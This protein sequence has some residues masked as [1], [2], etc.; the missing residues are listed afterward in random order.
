MSLDR[1][2]LSTESAIEVRSADDGKPAVLTG[3]AAL[4][5]HDSQLLGPPGRQFIERIAPGAFKRSVDA[6]GDIIATVDHEDRLILGRRSSGTLTLSENEKGLFV[7]VSLPNT[8]Y[9]S[10]LVESVQRGDISGMSFSFKNPQ[11][12]WGKR[13]VEGR[14]VPTRT[15]SDLELVEVAFVI[16]PA[17][18]QTDIA[19]RSLSN[20]EERIASDHKSNERRLVLA[21]AG[22]LDTKSS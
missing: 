17:Y 22:L 7:E 19:L 9:A 4:Y 15:I 14:S 18:T 1:R 10:D 11:D 3:W 12:E 6:N 13:S 2:Y 8:T 20:W 16:R 21:D 5:N